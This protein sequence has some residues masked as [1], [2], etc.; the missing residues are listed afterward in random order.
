MRMKHSDDPS[1]FLE[2]EADL[3]DMIKDL[4]SVATAPEHYG[5]LIRLGAAKV[6]VGLLRCVSLSICLSVACLSACMLACICLQVLHA[7]KHTRTHTRA[8]AQS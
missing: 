8:R 2:S 3:H 5:E 4:H 7:H 1:K 6:V